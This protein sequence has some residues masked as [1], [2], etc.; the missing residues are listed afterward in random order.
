M[1]PLQHRALV[2]PQ[3]TPRP[4]TCYDQKMRPHVATWPSDGPHVEPRTTSEILLLMDLMASVK[5]GTRRVLYEPF[6]LADL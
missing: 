3:L 6:E 2:R 4:P 1:T 5:A